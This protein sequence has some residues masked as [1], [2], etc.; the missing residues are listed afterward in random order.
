[1]CVQAFA[2]LREP[3]FFWASVWTIV[4]QCS[5]SLLGYSSAASSLSFRS[6]AILG[7]NL[8]HCRFQDQCVSDFSAHLRIRV[9]SC[10]VNYYFCFADV[11]EFRS[12]SPLR[13]TFRLAV[14]SLSV[15]GCGVCL[16]SPMVISPIIVESGS[17]H[18]N[19]CVFTCP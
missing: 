13:L 11:S 16:P 4:A 10:K 19:F 9:F 5:L 6:F 17:V 15:A 14:V 7:L 3:L 8:D 12:V 1:M 2:R 18:L